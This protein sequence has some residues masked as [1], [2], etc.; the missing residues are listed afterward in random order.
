MGSLK[1]KNSSDKRYFLKPI[2]GLSFGE[3]DY[4]MPAEQIILIERK[5]TILK[6]IISLETSSFYEFP[7]NICTIIMSGTHC[8]LILIHVNGHFPSRG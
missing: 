7:H 4:L 2:V 1:L 5:A 3:L 6:C 8:K